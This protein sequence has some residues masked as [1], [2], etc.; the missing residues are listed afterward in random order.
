VFGLT[1]HRTRRHVAGPTEGGFFVVAVLESKDVADRF[2]QES[3]MPL[4]PI[5]GGL[6]GPPQERGALI[7][8]SEGIP[9]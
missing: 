5:D 7:V 8:Y 6:A 4:M 3:I 9:G 2:V 1:L